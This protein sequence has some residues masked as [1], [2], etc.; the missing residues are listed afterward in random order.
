ME[1][2][3]HKQ[4]SGKSPSAS[5]AEVLAAANTFRNPVAIPARDIVP[6][7]VIS[8][9]QSTVSDI[10]INNDQFRNETWKI[11]FSDK[12]ARKDYARIQPGT[13]IF[14]DKDTQELL[15]ED[16]G[17][18]AD[19]RS[20]RYAGQSATPQGEQAVGSLSDIAADSPPAV[21]PA[22]SAG[23]AVRTG[24]EKI[25][26]GRLADENSTVSHLLLQNPGYG[27]DAWRII[28]AD[29]NRDKAF[30]QIQEGA[31]IFIDPQTLELSWRQVSPLPVAAAPLEEFDEYGQAAAVNVPAAEEELPVAEEERSDPFSSNLVRAVQS[32][33]GKSY[34]EI[35]CYGLVVRGLS[36][37]GIQYGGRGGLQDQLMQMAKSKGL[38]EN[39]YMTGEGLIEVSGEKVFT[40]SLNTVKNVEKAAGEIYNE[41]TPYLQ[42]GYI[43]SF[44]TPTR[45]HTGIISQH[46][47]MW[48][49]INSGYMDNRIEKTGRSKGVGEEVLAK[50]I[51]NWCRVAAK[52][53]ESLVITLGRLQ[54]E[55]LRTAQRRDQPTLQKVL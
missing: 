18:P 13:R 30:T 35:D 17:A 43:L 40:A 25:S 42:K 48:T 44:S 12:N 54:E 8:E 4:N 55:K 1:S 45:G 41:M 31:E 23:K 10:L 33:L 3:C 38:P 15:W 5:F 34:R 37:M 28:Q 7:G 29:S 2:I 16:K 6:V 24:G 27:R 22:D 11:I 39:A 21:L 47:Q 20:T 52:S 26:L 53:G 50:E 49:F 9:E 36:R 32:Y 14:I 51:K 46:D 19:S